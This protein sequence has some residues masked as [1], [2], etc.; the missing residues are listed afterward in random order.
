MKSSGRARLVEVAQASAR[1]L[2]LIAAGAGEELSM[3]DA[4]DKV[5]ALLATVAVLDQLGISYALIGGV[6]VGVV[7]GVPRATLDTDLAVQS[8]FDRTA[9]VAA[10]VGK[11]FRL[12]GE[13]GHSVN[14]R[15][16]NG[17][18]VQFAFDPGFDDWIAD[19]DRIDVGGVPV[20]IVR[21]AH[22]IEMK[23][24]AAA[25]PSRRRSKA[26]RDEADIALLLGDVP[27][28]DEGW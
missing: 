12:V 26:L 5:E 13:F 20:R 4:P 21:K 7:S 27:D 6:A 22:L 19:A 9:L 14:F 17:E 1:D 23:R 15:H 24:R 28:P 18:P 16:A 10:L 2:V 25:D 8:S 11:G 3:E